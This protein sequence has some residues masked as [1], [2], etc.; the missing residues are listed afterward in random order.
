MDFLRRSIRVFGVQAKIFVYLIFLQKYAKRQK[1]KHNTFILAEYE[2]IYHGNSSDGRHV[3][4]KS[5]PFFFYLALDQT[6]YCRP[7]TPAIVV[8]TRT[9]CCVL[10]CDSTLTRHGSLCS[11]REATQLSSSTRLASRRRD[12]GGV[13]LRTGTAAERIAPGRPATTANTTRREATLAVHPPSPHPLPPPSTPLSSH[14]AGLVGGPG[15]NAWCLPA[16]ASSIAGLGLLSRQ[17]S[18]LS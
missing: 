7:P 8:F 14:A 1:R 11:A 6:P 3:L 2:K 5:L 18:E 16:T 4:Q 9:L 12:A 15:R 10:S 13:R 17:L